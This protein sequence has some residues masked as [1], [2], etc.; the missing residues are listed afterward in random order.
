MDTIITDQGKEF[1]NELV[2]ELTERLQTEHRVTSAYHPQSNGQRERDNR[3]LKDC[4]TKVVNDHGNDWD[5]YIP[6]ESFFITYNKI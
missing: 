1:T 3:T 4:L 5:T 2:E 6:G